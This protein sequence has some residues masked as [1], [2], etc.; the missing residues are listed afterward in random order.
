M[1]TINEQEI[2]N[3]LFEQLAMLERIETALENG[4]ER[5]AEE[6]IEKIKKEINRKLN[7]K[8]AV[9]GLQ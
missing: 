9:P 8:P 4:G 7:Q 3:N 2:D 1:I 6:E 5:L